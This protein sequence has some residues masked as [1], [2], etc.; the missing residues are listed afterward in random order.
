[1]QGDQGSDTE[2]GGNGGEL[3]V[4]S[5]AG[6]TISAAIEISGAP[7]DGQGGDVFFMSILDTVQTGTI[8]AQGRGAESDGGT[9]E[10]DSHQGV[11]LR[12]IDVHGGE[13]LPDSG[14]ALQANA[15]C[16]LT[17]PSGV[18]ISAEGD[19]GSIH[20]SAGAQITA[21]GA[22]KA[23][24]PIVLEYRELLPIVA[25]GTFL[26]ELDTPMQN[27]SLTPCG[28]FPPSGCG[29]GDLDEGETCDPPPGN[30]VSC[31]GCSS[32]CQIEVCGNDV[33]DC[34]EACDDG[35]TADGDGCHGD[36]SRIER[37]GDGI[38]DA[39]ETCDDGNTDPCD[40][41]SATCQTEGCD[42][43]V[44]E[45]G[46]ECEPP[47][48]GGCS[49]NCL[50]FIPPGCG[51]GTI[52][53]EEE[54]DDGNV[55]DGDGCS[56]QCREERCGN[57]TLDPGEMCD[58]FNLNGCDGCSPSCTTETCGNG[59]QDCGEQCDD[60][61]GNGAPGGSCLR[62][63]CIPGPTCSTA[64]EEPCIPC[65]VMTDCG[66]ACGAIACVNG[67]CTP[68]APPSCDDHDACNGVEVCDPAIGCKDAPDPVCDDGDAC[69][70]DTCDSPTGCAFTLLAG[71]DLVQ[72]R[73]DAAR[74]IVV[75]AAPSDIA[76]PIRT[77]LLKKLSGIQGRVIAAA[78]GAGNSKKVRKA[79][80]AAN[81]QLQATVRLVNKQ[82]GKKITQPTA[83]AIV[84]ALN[85]LP[86]LIA[87]LI[88]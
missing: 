25:G 42:N 61:A 45:C 13:N 21:T 67:V 88:P 19:R 32:T 46:E 79:L 9:V 53:G 59:I 27:L 54:C 39:P 33:V 69:T 72:C 71:F 63:V 38:T 57:G 10:F 49:A 73:L 8:L 24:S 22:L 82:R 30:T 75:G 50:T 26:P 2:G 84:D 29:D 65:A 48:V 74:A 81:R 40:G 60:G 64:G 36:C 34:G 14:G 62:D 7:P 78:Q 12:P 1:M 43:G 44:V 83:T 37:C 56:H 76:G 4:F 66:N 51:N 68:A 3:N 58:D 86:S 80:K 85:V 16:D 70:T 55:V 87:P 6:L 35:N 23:G 18:T 17:V 28:G 20:L 15:W 11:T 41:C 77:K 5:A 31:D 47:G 52:A